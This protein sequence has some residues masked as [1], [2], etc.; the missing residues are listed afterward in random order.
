VIGP[1]TPGKP[2]ACPNA[3]NFNLSTNKNRSKAAPMADDI[4][5][6][7]PNLPRDCAAPPQVPAKPVDGFDRFYRD[8]AIKAVNK[9]ENQ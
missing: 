8:G 6:R 4:P 9:E 5:I 2:P 7:G 1:G 3:G